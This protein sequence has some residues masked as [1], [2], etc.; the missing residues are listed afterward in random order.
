[1]KKDSDKD[2]GLPLLYDRFG[3]SL[4][5]QQKEAKCT[6]TNKERQRERHMPDRGIPRKFEQKLRLVSYGKA[7]TRALTVGDF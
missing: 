1:M 7:T 3:I 6:H 5:R 4:K 2:S